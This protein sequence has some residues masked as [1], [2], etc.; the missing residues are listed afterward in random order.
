MIIMILGQ[1]FATATV[2]TVD[3]DI[4]VQDLAYDQLKEELLDSSQSRYSFCLCGFVSLID[5]WNRNHSPLLPLDP[6][7]NHINIKKRYSFYQI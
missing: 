3:Q 5:L 2:M 1:S 7:F 4:V 6:M